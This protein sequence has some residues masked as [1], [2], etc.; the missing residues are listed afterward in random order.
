MRRV[1]KLAGLLLLLAACQAPPPPTPTLTR[2]FSAPTLEPS[3]Q[4]LIRTSDE[5]YSATLSAGISDPTAAALPRNA[6]LPPLV[7]STD[8]A[9]V[10][11][12]VL[13]LAQGQ[14][15]G[16]LYVPAQEERV[17]AV[18]IV[19]QTRSAFASFAEALR[20]A[21]LVS[22]VIDPRFSLSAEEMGFLVEI[23]S[24]AGAVDPSHLAVL[25]ELDHSETALNACALTELCDALILLSPQWANLPNDALNAYL[26]RPVL[27][28]AAQDDSVSFAAAVALVGAGAVQSAQTATGR[29][30]GML[31]LDSQLSGA[32]IDWLQAQWQG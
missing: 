22:L 13:S 10:Q 26:P 4:V 1:A 12:V 15:N 17:P 27:V 25:A 31:A 5:L 8:T 28:V 14:V 21:G 2:A 20:G 6:P 11:S 18:L 19:A 32:L 24:E 3:P 7:L 30:V 23:L 9:G 16:D 29:G